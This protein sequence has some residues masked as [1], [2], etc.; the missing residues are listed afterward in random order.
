MLET[1]QRARTMGEVVPACQ[2]ESRAP[3]EMDNRKMSARQ[4]GSSCGSAPGLISRERLSRGG[5]HLRRGTTRAAAR[6]AGR[7][8]ALSTYPPPSTE[9]NSTGWTRSRRAWRVRDRTERGATCPACAFV[10]PSAAARAISR[11]SP[12]LERRS[13]GLIGATSTD[14]LARSCPTS[15]SKDAHAACSLWTTNATCASCSATCSRT[16]AARPRR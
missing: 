7:S 8:G 15:S 11:E 9:R 16:G 5:A 4:H 2:A 6:A 14:N 12:H 1:L 13:A 10:T 3:G